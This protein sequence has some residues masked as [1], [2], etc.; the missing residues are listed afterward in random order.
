MR[1]SVQSAPNVTPMIDVMLVL[2]II[3]MLMVPTLLDGFVAEPPA[4]QNFR[5]HPSDPTDVTLGIDA[6][7][8]YY[9]NKVRIPLRD[10]GTRLRAIYGNGTPNHLLYLKADHSL[11]YETV[12]AALDS[13]RDNGVALIGMISQQPGDARR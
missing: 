5:D 2:L 1:S 3:F 4:A 12:L 10:L 8:N 13:A 9:L 6:N 11:Q 7:G